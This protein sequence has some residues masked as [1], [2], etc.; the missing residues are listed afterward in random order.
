MN[1]L[2]TCLTALLLTVAASGPAFAQKASVAHLDLMRIWRQGV[3]TPG[4]VGYLPLAQKQAETALLQINLAID[5]FGDPVKVNTILDKLLLV[6][7]PDSEQKN[8][9]KDTSQQFGLTRAAASILAEMQVAR[10][11]PDASP[12]VQR[13]GDLVMQ[14]A[15]HVVQ[16][17]REARTLADDV[18]NKPDQSKDKLVKV[19]DY[20]TTA[21]NGHD[22]DGD[23]K[24]SPAEGGLE[25]I[26]QNMAELLKD[27]GF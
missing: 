21:I 11:R 22:D 23:G 24:I 9:S 15:D 18:R 17:T 3:D 1:R 6:L 16:V 25:Q 13:I 2:T 19:R 14:S 8:K 5:A 26:S 4:N 27:E 20:I 7:D 12:N 10:S